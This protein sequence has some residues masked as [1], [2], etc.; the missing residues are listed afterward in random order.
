ME[1]L[2]ASDPPLVREVWIRMWVWYKDAMD[3]PQ[4][5]SRVAITTMLAWQVKQYRHIPY[6]GKLILMGVNP[7]LAK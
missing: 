4:P 2:L 7:F 1:S 5:S 3:R 6:P